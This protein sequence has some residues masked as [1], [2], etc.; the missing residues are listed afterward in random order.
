MIK[1]N[2]PKRVCD[3]M[4]LQQDKIKSWNINLPE[5][6]F[7][8][9]EKE[10]IDC[11]S[12]ILETIL[13]NTRDVLTAIN[14]LSKEKNSTGVAILIK[15]LIENTINIAYTPH[16]YKKSDLN[17]V[18]ETFENLIKDS[19]KPMFEKNVLIKANLSFEKVEF[20]K[21][22]TT[23]IYEHYR[24]VCQV[25]HPSF[26]QTI[27]ILMNKGTT[28]VDNINHLSLTKDELLLPDY[29]KIA[30]SLRDELVQEIDIFINKL[31]Y[32]VAYRYK[33]NEYVSFDISNGVLIPSLTEK[34]KQ[35]K[36]GTE[37]K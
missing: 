32:E 3:F 13:I 25:A 5:M 31:G 22:E 15:T 12:L 16:F 7:S 24:S 30:L 23:A 18:I 1:V 33:S 6:F 14:T 9:E 8:R 20:N 27:S 37:I 29:L 2:T 35:Y 17:H 36:V 19:K 21:K 10:K 34:G 28:S 11:I 26:K 4:E